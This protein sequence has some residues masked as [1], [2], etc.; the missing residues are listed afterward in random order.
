MASK[1]A[2]WISGLTG[3][4][5]MPAAIVHCRGQDAAP[6]APVPSLHYPSTYTLISRD[7][8]TRRARELEMKNPGWR[9]TVDATGYIAK[10]VCEACSTPSD[11][12]GRTRLS[13][14][15]RTRFGVFEMRNGALLGL[16]H[17]DIR[18]SK[19]NPYDVR[20]R[21][22][23]LT[24]GSDPSP[25]AEVLVLV[26]DGHLLV[27]G[28]L[29]P[30]LAPPR[31]PLMS[32]QTLQQTL[33]RRSPDAGAG[34]PPFTTFDFVMRRPDEVEARLTSCLDRDCLDTSTG[35]VLTPFLASWMTGRVDAT[36]TLQT[37]AP[38][39]EDGEAPP[40]RNTEGRSG[41]GD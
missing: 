16:E 33:L 21:Q 32:F 9:I 36:I 34:T 39:V 25:V 2:A 18:R 15:D 8:E 26:R 5:L 31:G 37:T 13:P 22:F 41:R 6:V 3:L 4:A 29:W 11:P 7:E 23:L 1:H 24:T 28:H 12:D 35:E 17:A 40:T 20:F 30:N 10:A 38:F 19:E 27:Q 14:S